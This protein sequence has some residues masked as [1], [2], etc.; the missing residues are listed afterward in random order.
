M[1]AGSASTQ[2]IPAPPAATP[3]GTVIPRWMQDG[4]RCDRAMRVGQAAGGD[5]GFALGFAVMIAR[6]MQRQAID[7]GAVEALRLDCHSNAY[8]APFA[9]VGGKSQNSVTAGASEMGVALKGRGGGA[10]VERYEK[11]MKSA[12]TRQNGGDVIVIVGADM[13]AFCL[14]GAT[15]RFSRRTAIMDQNPILLH[16]SHPIAAIAAKRTPAGFRQAWLR[17]A[18]DLMGP[19]DIDPNNRDSAIASTYMASAPPD[20]RNVAWALEQVRHL[21]A[22]VATD[23]FGV[24]R[25]SLATHHEGGGDTEIWSWDDL[26]QV[27]ITPGAGA[28]R[29][30][31]WYMNEA[32]LS[33]SRRDPV[34]HARWS[35]I[36]HRVIEARRNANGGL[37]WLSTHRKIGVAPWEPITGHALMRAAAEW[38]PDIT[39]ARLGGGEA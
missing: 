34:F 10:G 15:S 17:A 2:S 20:E 36:H 14:C 6:M 3:I 4:S 22:G 1:R 35:R 7:I 24:G 30:V 19:I 21:R 16:Q 9:V 18:V 31:A 37:G 28:G 13:S 12:G 29:A 11:L 23:I 8:A 25:S 5:S 32:I 26:A 38:G 33:R 39:S 27:R